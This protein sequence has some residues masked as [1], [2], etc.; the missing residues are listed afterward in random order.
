[1][2]IYQAIGL[3]LLL[4]GPTTRSPLQT[5]SPMLYTELLLWIVNS[6]LKRVSST[7]IAMARLEAGHVDQYE[8][9]TRR[10]R[11]YMCGI[12]SIYKDDCIEDAAMVSARAMNS[13]TTRDGRIDSINGI[14]V[15]T[16]DAE[17]EVDDDFCE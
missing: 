16:Q 13:N 11:A 5:L 15:F 2:T 9:G 17:F 14:E 4:K 7:A 3:S 10:E 12:S 1:M 6:G 8:P